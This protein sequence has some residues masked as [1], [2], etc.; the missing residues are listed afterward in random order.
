[1]ADTKKIEVVTVD[2]DEF[3]D[4][5]KRVHRM[6]ISRAEK[7][8]DKHLAHPTPLNDTKRIDAVKDV[9]ALVHMMELVEYMS[10]EITDLRELMH[11]EEQLEGNVTTE[12]PE[13]FSQDKTKFIN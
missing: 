5:L 12:T 2:Q 8:R 9:Y 1:M 10:E 7:A 4:V 13:M 11:L 3:N 6:L